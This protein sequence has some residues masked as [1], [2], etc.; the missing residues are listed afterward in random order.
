MEMYSG[1]TAC[2]FYSIHKHKTSRN[3]NIHYQHN[4][5]L[6]STSSLLR[7][8]AISKW[9]VD[10]SNRFTRIQYIAPGWIRFLDSWWTGLD[11][12]RAGLELII[13]RAN[14]ASKIPDCGDRIK[15]LHLILI[16][17]TCFFNVSFN[18]RLEI[19]TAM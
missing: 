15:G 7:F 2:N 18:M 16:I 6:T 10:Y 4:T 17:K 1:K 14:Y 5:L 19:V 3:Y 12:F 8:S 9:T 13:A 11:N